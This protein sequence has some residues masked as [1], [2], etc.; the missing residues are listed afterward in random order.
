MTRGSSEARPTYRRDPR[1]TSAATDT[2]VGI[3]GVTTQLGQLVRHSYFHEAQPHERA[4]A[5]AGIAFPNSFQP[6]QRP[7][8]R[9][10][11]REKKSPV[12][13]AL[14][15][16]RYWARTS[17]PQLVDTERVCGAVR[18]RAVNRHG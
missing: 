7:H 17:D 6:S 10:L 14:H 16:G 1:P 5:V 4:T 13:G 3:V 15:D 18:T 11:R 8:P 12:S 9:E 2:R